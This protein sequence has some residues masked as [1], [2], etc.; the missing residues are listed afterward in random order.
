MLA[1]REMNRSQHRT[2][3]VMKQPSDYPAQFRQCLM[4]TQARHHYGA[5]FEQI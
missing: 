2:K 3:F 5:S 1:V 4:P